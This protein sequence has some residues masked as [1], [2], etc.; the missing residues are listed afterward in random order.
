[1]VKRKTI[2]A[3]QLIIGMIILLIGIGG[4]IYSITLYSELKE[5]MYDLK[6]FFDIKESLST[7]NYTNATKQI[8]SMEYLNLIQN[9]TLFKQQEVIILIL[10]SALAI[11]LSLLFIFRG[12][13]NISEKKLKQR[14]III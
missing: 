1:M 13:V 14:E 5:E 12:L 3:I 8:L 11:I 9:K 4:L 6:P 7:S 10:F 2:G